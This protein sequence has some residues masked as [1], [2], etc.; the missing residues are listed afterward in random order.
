MF[1]LEGG[2]FVFARCVLQGDEVRILLQ[3]WQ[4]AFEFDG[5]D[6]DA[7]ALVAAHP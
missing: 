5:A 7:G 6:F 2:D 3:N 4:E 1:F